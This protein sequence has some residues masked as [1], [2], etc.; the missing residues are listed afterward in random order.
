MFPFP[1]CVDTCAQCRATS[2]GTEIS[3]VDTGFQKLAAAGI[4]IIFASGDSGS[5][6]ALPEPPQPP[7]CSH[8]KPGKAGVEFKG[9]VLRNLSIGTAP[10]AEGT[11]STI[12]PASLVNSRGP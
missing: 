11:R 1:F 7:Q 12:P 3:D 10:G 6:Y 5:G 4:T 8:V 2:K 9:G